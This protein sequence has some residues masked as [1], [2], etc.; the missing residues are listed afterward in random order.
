MS[1][2]DRVS[3]RSAVAKP[4]SRSRTHTSETFAVSFADMSDD[5][6]LAILTLTFTASDPDA[7]LTSLS[8]YV[9]LTR[10]QAGS[11]NVDLCVSVAHPARF[12]VIQKWDSEAHARAHLDSDVMI[13]MAEA[14][15]GV[16]SE[17]PL[18]DLLEGISAH[19][20]N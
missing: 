15:R 13:E 17:A 12:V 8:K 19:D 14:C 5:I 7:L 1:R 6:E 9:V 16:L 3:P 4:T 20:L 10:G 2:R 11:R 18:I